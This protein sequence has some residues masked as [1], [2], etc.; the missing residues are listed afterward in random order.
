MNINVEP[1]M[2]KPISIKL[3]DKEN[4]ILPDDEVKESYPLIPGA[5][6]G[7]EHYGFWIVTEDKGEECR[8]LYPTQC[9]ID[10]IGIYQDK[11]KIY[12]AGKSIPW[13]FDLD[14]TL[15]SWATFSEFSRRDMALLQDSVKNFNE[16]AFTKINTYRK[17]SL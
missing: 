15:T 4:V 16:E 11:L 17:R 8:V 9:R 12:E 7:G 1:I 14:G 10:G 3:S 2:S 6:I 13:E 5:V